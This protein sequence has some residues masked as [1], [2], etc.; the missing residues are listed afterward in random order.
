MT[1]EIAAVAVLT[2]EASDRLDRLM[3]ESEARRGMV[4]FSHEIDE[5]RAI[6]KKANF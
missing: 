5:A 3:E 2:G 6:L 4:E 1:S